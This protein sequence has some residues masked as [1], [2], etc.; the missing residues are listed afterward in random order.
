MTKYRGIRKTRWI[1]GE[2]LRDRFLKRVIK[3]DSCWMWDGPIGNHG[4]GIMTFKRQRDTAPRWSVKIFKKEDPKGL[5]VCHKCDNRKC[6]NPEH[7]FLGTPDD[8]I[9]D[10]MKKGRQRFGITRK[11]TKLTDEQ[12]FFIIDNPKIGNTDLAKRFKVSQ[13]LVSNIRTGRLR[14]HLLAGR[15]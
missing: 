2:S 1:M 10:M 3:T 12:V 5:Y 6:V 14:R 7:L 9:Q 11:N 13:A 4:Y 15:Q 8:N